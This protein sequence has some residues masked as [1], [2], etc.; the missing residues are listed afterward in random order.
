MPA[1]IPLYVLRKTD[2]RDALYRM[3]LDGSGTTT[4][5]AADKDN[6]IDGIVRIGHGQRVVGY[7]FA[8]DKR[9]TV[10]FDPDYS[11]LQTALGK[12][13]PGEPLIDFVGASADGQKLLIF[14]SG[15]TRSG[16]LLPLRPRDQASRR[17]SPARGLSST[18]R[19]WRRC[20]RS[21]CPRPTERRSR[22][23]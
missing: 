20:G 10:Y 15:D 11:S 17:R 12:V 13:I 19:R 4:L 6:D 14:A 5:V 2:G 16:H 18:P 3:T 7:T 22:R 23:T 21:A 8:G 1:A 9:R